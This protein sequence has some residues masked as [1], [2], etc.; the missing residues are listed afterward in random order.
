MG[1]G[2]YGTFFG[3]LAQRLGRYFKYESGIVNIYHFVEWLE[4]ESLRRFKRA[5]AEQYARQTQDQIPWYFEPN[6]IDEDA[7]ADTD[8]EYRTSLL[9]DKKANRALIRQSKY[10]AKYFERIGVLEA[11]LRILPSGNPNTKPLIGDTRKYFAVAGIMLDIKGDPPLIVP[12]EE[13]LLQKAVLENVLP[14]LASRFPERAQELVTAYHDLIGGKD[15]DA[16]FSNAFKTLEEIARSLTGNKKFVFQEKF[17]RKHFPLLHPMIHET[18]IRL[19]RHRG[20]KGAHGKDAPKPHEMR[21]LLFAICNIA[22]LLLD[23][24]AADPP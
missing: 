15:F 1:T 21:Y 17:L 11:L 22:L 14:R 6:T 23:Y 20:D 4:S 12:M 10:Q 2:D 18:M 13:P 24:P 9:K 3:L 5:I 19:T 8:I 7:L 16:I